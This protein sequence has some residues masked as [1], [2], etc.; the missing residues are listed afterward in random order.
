[1]LTGVDEETRT[2]LA[3]AGLMLPDADVEFFERLREAVVRANEKMNL[4]RLVAP[5]DFWRKHVLDAALPFLVVEALR[6]LPDRL[7]AADLGAGAGFP[8]LVLARLRPGW[9]VAL[10]ERTQ[11]KALFLEETIEALGVP[12]AYVVPFDARDAP[13][14]APVLAGACGVVA[15]RAVG[16]LAAVTAAAAPLLARGGVLVHYKGGDVDAAELKEGARE[17]HRRGLRQEAPVSYA[18]PPDARRAVVLTVSPAT[19][20]TRSGSRRPKRASP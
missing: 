14:R 12:N 17:A 15:A 13:G 20:R 8:G 7:L 16:R 19:R 4:T 11:K 3:A 18:L 6:A 1:M 5:R 2:L 10:I 9:D